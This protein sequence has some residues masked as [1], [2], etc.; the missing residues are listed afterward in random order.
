MSGFETARA[1]AMKTCGPELQGD[2]YAMDTN[3]AFNNAKKNLENKAGMIDK[4]LIKVG[5]EPDSIRKQFDNVSNA[6]R[7]NGQ[8][9]CGQVLDA[10]QGAYKGEIAVKPA[11]PDTAPKIVAQ[12]GTPERQTASIQGTYNILKNRGAAI[13]AATGG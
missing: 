5:R 12:S 9:A 8:A 3:G 1:E 7:Q 4:G 13:D 11:T 6:L 10:L 2:G